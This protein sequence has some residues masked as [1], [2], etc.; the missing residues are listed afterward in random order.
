MNEPPIA[1]QP[2]P[3]TQE[4]SSR[5]VPSR[6]N[7]AQRFIRELIETALA[8]LLLFLVIQAMVENFQV[9]G[10][11]MEPNVH[12]NEFILVNK[13]V[14]F[15][16]SRATLDRLLPFVELGPGEDLYL[17]HPPR[18]GEIVV[19]YRPEVATRDFIKRVI[20]EPGDVVEARQGMVYI[21]GRPHRE[22]YLENRDFNDS[23]PPVVVP[24]GRYFV[25]GDNRPTSQDSRD[26]GTVAEEQ[27]IGKAWLS[28]WPL[29][30]L[31]FVRHPAPSAA[32]AES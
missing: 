32:A 12:D 27:I 18:R 29:D 9:R 21:D 24:K 20:G 19:L 1:G 10:S 31:G 25:M 14:Y 2:T 28:Y 6:G 5:A 22:P 4:S 11:S 16:V 8:A 26:W 17:F 30:Q 15:H 3:P 7:A 23:L 13:A